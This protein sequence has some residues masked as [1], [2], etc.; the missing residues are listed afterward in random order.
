MSRSLFFL[1]SNSLC[2]ITL[3]CVQLLIWMKQ[4]I[5]EHE[6]DNP[7]DVGVSKQMMLNNF[8]NETE[9]TIDGHISRMLQWNWIV[10]SQYT[11]NL[12]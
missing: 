1:I 10:V 9:R 4:D 11:G 3:F 7:Y 6:G 8:S 2:F 5:V 12:T